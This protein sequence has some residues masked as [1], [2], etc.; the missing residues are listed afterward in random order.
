MTAN[1]ERKPR[2]RKSKKEAEEPQNGVEIPDSDAGE[3]LAAPQVDELTSDPEG[4]EFLELPVLPLRGTVVFPL[5][6][7][8]LAAA[9]A[10]SLRLIDHVMSA[11]RTVALV[12]Q[13]DAELEGAGPD[14]VYRVGTIATIH[15]MMRVP[16]GTVRLA[17]QG[18]ERMRLLEFTGE[19]PFLVAKVQRAPETVDESVEVDAL[20]RNTLELFQR[21]VSLVAHMP[22]ELVTAALN[23]DDPRHLVYL[24]A[25]NLRMDAEERQRLLELDS[26]REKL[27]ALNTFIAK[28]L[29]VL[30]LGR[31]IQSDVQE[32]LGKNQREYFLRE[33]LKA[34]QR[35]LGESSETEAEITELRQKIDDSAMPDEAAKEA[36]RELDRLSKLPPAAAEYGVIKTYLDWLTSLPWNTSTEDEIDVA[37]A[38]QILDDEHYDLEKIKDR[39]LE[40]LA[41]RKLKQDAAAELGETE[42]TLSREPILCFVGPPG[43]GKTSLAQSIAH[44]LGR[45]LTRMSLG[46]VRDEAEIRGHRRTYVGA[47]PGRIIQAIRRAG[48]ND[49][50]FVLDEVDK[51]GSDW[52]GDP[53]S[54]LLEVLDPE[55]NFN[56][57]DHYLDV[58]F[59][60]SKVMFI[61]TANL[62][63]S[64]PAPL[65]DRMEVL[66]LNGYTDEEKLA[67]A[68]RFL[69]PK[70]V[71]AHGLASEPLEWNDE[72]LNFIVQNYTREAG[73]RN[74]E[75]EIATVSRKIAT[76]KAEGREYSLTVGPEEVREY[77]GRPRHY[78]EERSQRTE[79]PGVAIGVGV[80][81]VGGDIMFIEASRMP[82]KGALTV[83]GQL[84]D[85]MKESAT[86]AMSF[87]RSRT[88]DLGIDPDF[89]KESDVHL[90]VPAGAI[91]K[92][93]PSAG[94]AMT[95]A[96]VSL[97]TGVPVRDDV[98]MTGEITLRG[99][100]LPVGGIKLKALAARR[101][102]VTTFVLPKRNEA[103][104]DD[105]PAELREEMT[106][107]LAETMDDV[108]ATALPKKYVDSHPG[109]DDRADVLEPVADVRTE[110]PA[111]V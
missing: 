65:R 106:F 92:D 97:L 35:E 19:E 98:A 42:P 23:V 31:K 109:I 105:L 91:P 111:L 70:Q 37:K 22:D 56:F 50:V 94:T 68:H 29:D 63:D 13:K 75:R 41:V 12:M 1:S 86:A 27:V 103:D 34:I 104:L 47:M 52:R 7:V 64:I 100:V 93:G 15:Q 76:R 28:E 66:D 10:R 90:H 26:V 33:Q 9:Q 67:I 101:A 16:D 69:I 48:S 83:T 57:R 59:D 82:G 6:V 54:A 60:L 71:K 11:D 87:V 81:G 5:T 107:V 43:V 3:S 38:R 24:V 72:G 80:S 18:N 44:A 36:R 110:E 53:S 45:K 14:D 95:T 108:L 84:G 51:L 21:L 88:T 102:G 73:V 77:L 32:E 17:V 46:G 89:F 40:Y 39:I 8:P 61:A 58:P 96:L 20:T 2:A 30:E 74:L 62:L 99:Q 25:T 55:Q 79:Q 4:S 85:V 78:Y 49:P